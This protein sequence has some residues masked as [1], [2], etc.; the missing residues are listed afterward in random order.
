MISKLKGTVDSIKQNH[1]VIDVNGVGYALLCSN[2]TLQQ[3]ST[4]GMAVTVF[5]EV[6]LRQ[7]NITLFGFSSE[8]E[9]E[10][11]RMLL[12]IQGVGGKVCLNIL[13]VLSPQAI[14]SCL[15]MQDHTPLTNA[16]GVGPKLA[17]RIV[18]ELKGKN[19]LEHF[20]AP[21]VT[22]V[23]SSSFASQ[24]IIHTE[25]L[26]ALINL[27]YRKNEVMDAL[28]KAQASGTVMSLDMLIP[29]ALQYLSKMNG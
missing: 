11:F 16:D 27:G 14:Q 24:D 2:K 20:S 13:S 6:L 12:T 23:S 9:R 10:T 18:R 28:S 26:S 5:V 3:F 29:Q 8:E 4:L 15:T 19:I 25:A 21:H 7:E 22:E 17:M 1:A